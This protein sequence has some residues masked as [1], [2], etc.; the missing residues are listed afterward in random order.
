MHAHSQVK[1]LGDVTQGLITIVTNKLSHELGITT[2][3]FAPTGAVAGGGVAGVATRATFVVEEKTA[4]RLLLVL[5]LFLRLYC[6]HKR[7][8]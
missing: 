4:C 7:N 6:G 2:I 1:I 8:T 5:L 3:S